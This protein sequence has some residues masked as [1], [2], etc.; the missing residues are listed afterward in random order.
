VIE[1]L[2]GRI[3]AALPDGIWGI[4]ALFAIIAVSLALPEQGC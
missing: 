2:M 3:I 4:V 1:N